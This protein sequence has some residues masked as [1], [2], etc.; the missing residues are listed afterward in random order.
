MLKS[1]AS[2]AVVIASLAVAS[3]Q[4]QLPKVMPGMTGT[5]NIPTLDLSEGTGP[6]TPRT[7]MRDGKVFSDDPLPWSQLNG[8]P[9]D[10]TFKIGQMALGNGVM[11]TD[12]TLPVKMGGGKLSSNGITANL[13]G[14]KLSGDF[15]MTQ[16]TKRA[17][18]KLNARGLSA[19]RLAKQLGYSEGV[20]KGPL[21]L[22]IDVRGTGN[23]VRE[24]LASLD[25]TVVGH[26]GE[27]RIRNDV[28]NAMGADIVVQILGMIGD[29]S[30]ETVARCAVLNVQIENGI[31]RTEKGIALSTDKMDATATGQIDLAN[32]QVALAVTPRAKSG[33]A[34]GLGDLG[35]SLRVV[36][37]LAQPQ[38]Q[39]NSDGV[40]NALRT[41][42]KGEQAQP[43]DTGD[44]C[45]AARIWNQKK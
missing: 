7:A 21:D 17:T 25:G 23:T 33:F 2:G 40:V 37:P 39:L 45:A 42:A 34:A 19:E 27:G 43:V 1:I 28:L 12:V 35:S 36:G 38:A 31:A 15:T 8:A 6:K 24:V 30:N 29:K 22:S 9:S 5:L 10:V 11:L 44:V 16:T 14:G 4:A 41:L 3:A 26:M 20:S 32:E 13:L 18:L